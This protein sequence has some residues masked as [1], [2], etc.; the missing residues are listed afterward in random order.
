MNLKHFV[1]GNGGTSLVN[2][3]GK[4]PRGGLELVLPAGNLSTEAFSKSVFGFGQILTSQ[5]SYASYA[6]NAIERSRGNMWSGH[7]GVD[8]GRFL[9]APMLI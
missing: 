1:V 9:Q 3:T 7:F 2:N 6:F 4:E 5:S 8:S